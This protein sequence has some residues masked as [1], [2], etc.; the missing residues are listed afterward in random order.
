MT[1]KLTLDTLARTVP[2]AVDVQKDVMQLAKDARSVLGY[3]LL[4]NQLVGQPLREALTKL[5]IE[6]LDVEEVHKYQKQVLEEIMK[7]PVRLLDGTDFNF[8]EDD[9]EDEEEEDDDEMDEDPNEEEEDFG[10]ANKRSITVYWG[11]KGIARYQKPI[12]EFVLCKAVMLKREVPQV[13]LF[14]EEVEKIQLKD[15]FLVAVLGQERYYVEVWN[16]PKFEGRLTKE[17]AKKM[18]PHTKAR[19]EKL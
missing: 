3:N 9:E 6:V 12:P 19:M 10:P 17:E 5:E 4:A 14:V 13:E 11:W 15:P 8:E 1:A 7:R 16:E 2:E 18:L